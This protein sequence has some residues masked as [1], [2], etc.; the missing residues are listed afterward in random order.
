MTPSARFST[1]A[2]PQTDKPFLRKTDHLFIGATI[3][4]ALLRVNFG[5]DAAEEEVE[6]KESVTHDFDQLLIACSFECREENADWLV[7]SSSPAVY[8]TQPAIPLNSADRAW[9]ELMVY[10]MTAKPMKI[11]AFA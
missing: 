9:I 5:A 10:K 11:D 4:F 1:Q 6:L 8:P 3:H 2:K 7:S